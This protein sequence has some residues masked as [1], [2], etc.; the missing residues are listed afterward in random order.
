MVPDQAPSVAIGLEPSRSAWFPTRSSEHTKGA[1]PGGGRRAQFDFPPVDRDRAY[2]VI[3][4]MRPIAKAHGRSVAQ[5][6]LAWLLHQP[7][8]TSV[9]VGAK[10]VDQLK[11]NLETVN[12]ELS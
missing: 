6:A 5:V 11:E 7:V 10:R 3:D 2:G 1:K 12:L 8:V 4:A 9:I